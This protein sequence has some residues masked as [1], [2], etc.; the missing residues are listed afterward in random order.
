ME[1]HE[2]MGP[3]PKF[4][5]RNSRYIFVPVSGFGNRTVSVTTETTE[6]PTETPSVKNG[7]KMA[8]KWAKTQNVDYLGS[9]AS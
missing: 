1:F 8:P 5:E 9:W 7:P 4:S 6:T 2:N 3:E